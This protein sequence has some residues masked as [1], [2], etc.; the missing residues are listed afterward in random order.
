M[1]TW[2]RG[3]TTAPASCTISQQTSEPSGEFGIS[4]TSISHLPP[5]KRLTNHSSGSSPQ[6]PEPIYCYA[7]H[8][9]YTNSIEIIDFG[10]DRWVFAWKNV[11]RHVWYSTQDLRDNSHDVPDRIRPVNCQCCTL[12][13]PK[14]LEVHR[15]GREKFRKSTWKSSRSLK[16]KARSRPVGPDSAPFSVWATSRVTHA[17]SFFDAAARSTFQPA[18][19]C[20]ITRNTLPRPRTRRRSNPSRF[21]KPLLVD[22]MPERIRYRSA[23]TG[24]SCSRRCAAIR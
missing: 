23:N 13:Q 21:F 10:L 1:S 5:R 18:T 17:R 14:S 22:S 20:R 19:L 15:K 3:P 7:I 11:A 16:T 2:S 6:L 9:I 12:K 4:D 8:T 24:V